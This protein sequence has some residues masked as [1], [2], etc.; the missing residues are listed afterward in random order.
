MYKKTI[1]EWLS[2][3]N[4]IIVY[5]ACICF[6]FIFGRVFILPLKSIV[7][8][9]LNSILGGVM[10]YVINVVGAM[11]EF[12]IGLNYVTVILVGILGVPGAFLLTA[13]KLFLG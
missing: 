9:I 2:L 4:T 8:L 6:L 3:D 10:I 13:L 7:K 1:G 12:H 11:F 5:L